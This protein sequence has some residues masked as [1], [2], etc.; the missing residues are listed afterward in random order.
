[1]TTTLDE[2]ERLRAAAAED[3]AARAREEVGAAEGAPALAART[4]TIAKYPTTAKVFYGVVATTLLGAEV[5]GGAGQI[6]PGTGQFFALN[7]GTAVPPSGT[8][9][10]IVYVPSRWVFRYDG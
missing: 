2:A 7:L 3:R 4:V 10:V 1:M 8:D 6:T 5:E 9:I